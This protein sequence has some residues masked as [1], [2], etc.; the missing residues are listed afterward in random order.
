MQQHIPIFTTGNTPSQNYPT[1][2]QE[3]PTA[4]IIAVAVVI[5]TILLVIITILS[6]L[7]VLKRK[8]Q[9]PTVQCDQ[10]NMP[11]I[12]EV[13]DDTDYQEL[14]A[15]KMDDDVM[16]NKDY[17]KLNVRKVDPLHNEVMTIKGN[18]GLDA[19]KKDDVICGEDYDELDAEKMDKTP[20]Y[21]SL[22]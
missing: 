22:R 7:L 20:Q 11:E 21:A 10:V 14:D 16:T 18:L 1:L 2:S 9:P 3:C 15:R 4:V 12:Y 8:K 13:V 6:V 19:S 5:I 17:Q